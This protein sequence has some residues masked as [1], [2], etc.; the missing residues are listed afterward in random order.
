MRDK[1]PPITGSKARQQP[2]SQTRSP[3]KA[4]L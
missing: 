4:A 2:E 3:T 1:I